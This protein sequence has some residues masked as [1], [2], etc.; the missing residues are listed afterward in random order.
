[1][2][3]KS[4]ADHLYSWGNSSR[5]MILIEFMVFIEVIDIEVSFLVQL[6]S[7]KKDFPRLSYACFS[8]P[9]LRCGN[10]AELYRVEMNYF[11]S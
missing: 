3:K 5:K 6:E 10:Y 9:M 8:K 4:A 7:P 11:C 1:M 2:K